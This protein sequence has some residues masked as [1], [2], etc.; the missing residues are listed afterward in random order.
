M[1]LKRLSSKAK[2]LVDKRGGSES[3]KEDAD[4]LRG[5]AKGGGSLADKAKAAAAAIKEPGAETPD[6]PEATPAAAA[7]EPERGR[8]DENVKRDR[9]H[10]R[11]GGGRH[12]GKGRH[13]GRGG[14]AGGGTV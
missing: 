8:S 6:A 4:E 10:E 2:E 14:G 12:G 3:V 7:A 13:R 5:I 11:A 9:H 1:D